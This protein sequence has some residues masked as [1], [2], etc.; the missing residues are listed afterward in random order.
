MGI[1][2]FERSIEYAP[3]EDY[4]YWFLGKAYLEQGRG[5][6]E[7]T[8]TE[9]REAIFVKTEA[10]LAAARETNP[11]NTD[12][13]A[14][15]ARFYKSWAARVAA[16]LR[17]EGLGEAEIASLQ[18]VRQTLLQQS[19]ENYEI[20]LTLSPNNPI[21]WNELAQLYAIDMG[22]QPRFEETIAHSLEVDEGV[23]Q[24][25]MLLGDL[26]SSQGDT[27][28][29]IEAYLRSLELKNNCTVRRVIGT[30]YAQESRWDDT[31]AFLEASVAECETAGDLWEMYRVLAITYANQGEVAQALETAEISLDLA[32]AD[33]QPMIQQMIDQLL[34]TES[35]V[36]ED[37]A[38]GTP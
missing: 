3:H 32:P 25:W 10:V 29:A 12:H 35:P 36:G 15:L 20:A 16:D 1:Q 7:E 5:L 33:Q 18:E 13:S 8:P 38:T 2:H 21:L 19:L 28:G 4:Y 37:P 30:L 23:E 24:T 17:A 34:G 27:D 11:L 6:G 9:Q 14:N 26:A 22:D 31:A